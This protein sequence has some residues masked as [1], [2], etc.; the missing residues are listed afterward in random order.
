MNRMVK[1]WTAFLLS[2]IMILSMAACGVKPGSGTGS[3]S[4]SAGEAVTSQQTPGEGPGGEA[5]GEPAPGEEPDGEAQG[6]PAP[7]DGLAQG[8]GI[9][10]IDAA[11]WIN[12]DI[13]EWV[14]H[15]DPARPQDDFHLSVNR[16][17]M[18]NTKIPDGYSSYDPIT[19]WAIEVDGQLLNILENPEKETD[20]ALIHDQALVQ[21]YYKMWLDWD[22]R[23]KLGI[24]PLADLLQPLRDVKTL[25][26]LT[27]YL[28]MPRTA[29]SATELLQCDVS[30]N[31]NKAED[32]AVYVMPMDLIFGDSM[33]YGYM[34]MDDAMAEPYYD[35]VIRHILLDLGYT[36]DEATSILKGCFTFEQ[37][38][39]D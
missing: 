1:K 2:F 26:E 10:G 29:I 5:Q 15:S 3:T 21:K 34:T 12:S 4:G 32:Y 37:D 33:Y 27:A 11:T 19:E 25:E 8:T 22:A 23:N 24:Q 31:W 20:E 35:D 9:P 7:D 38:I 17:W 16:E 36:D 13:Q 6:E 39:A 18:L 30:S 28:A 14:K